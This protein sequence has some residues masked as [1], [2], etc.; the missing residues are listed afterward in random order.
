MFWY[1]GLVNLQVLVVTEKKNEEDGFSQNVS[2][3]TKGSK[4]G[5]LQ[6]FHFWSFHDTFSGFSVIKHQRRCATLMRVFWF[7]FVHALDVILK[8]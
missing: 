5:F 7:T 8:W 1:P 4:V 3:P 6:S 2:F